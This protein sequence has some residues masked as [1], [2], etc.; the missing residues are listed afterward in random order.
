MGRVGGV[1]AARSRAT[2]C[3][4]PSVSALPDLL[5]RFILDNANQPAGNC[6]Y[7]SAAL[8]PRS[9]SEAADEHGQ[10]AAPLSFERSSFFRNKMTAGEFVIWPLHHPEGA[11]VNKPTYRAALRVARAARFF[12]PAPPF[13]RA[14]LSR[15]DAVLGWGRGA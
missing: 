4:A 8:S 5:C 6:V 7:S 11:V 14:R 9:P 1:E 3:L 13:Q 15:Y 10:R 2:I 12:E